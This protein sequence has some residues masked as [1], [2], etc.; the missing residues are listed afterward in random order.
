MFGN[1]LS[2]QA[3]GEVVQPGNELPGCRKTKSHAGLKAA[4]NTP[5][6]FCTLEYGAT[7]GDRCEVLWDRFFEMS[8]RRSDLEDNQPQ[9]GGADDGLGAALRAQLAHNGV[10]VE[11]DGMLADAQ[12]AG[13]G[14]VGQPFGQQLQHF[15]F[16][17]R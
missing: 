14:L 15:K 2:L 12:L 1:S 5:T 7:R 16:A 13:D 6:M 10:D 4:L 17:R 11:L 8:A 9:A 3:E